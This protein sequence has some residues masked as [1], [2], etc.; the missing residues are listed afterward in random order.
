MAP[1]S[2]ATCAG[3]PRHSV[4]YSLGFEGKTEH[5]PNAHVLTLATM[6]GHGMV[7]MSLAKK[8]IDWV[9][10]G[11]RTPEQACHYLTRFCSCGVFNPVA[12]EAD[13]RG[14]PRELAVTLRR[15][16]TSLAVALLAATGCSAPPQPSA[17]AAT[18]AAPAGSTLVLRGFTLID[19]NGGAPIA[20]AGLV[21][22]NGRITYVGPGAN[23][24]AP[25]GASVQDLTG[26]FVMPGLI[27]LHG[28]VAESDGI[29]QDPKTLFTRENVLANLKLYATYGVTT[30]ASMGTDQPIVYDL[31]R[32]QRAGR[33]SEAR[34]FTAGRGFTSTKGYPTQPGGIPGVPYELGK[35][36]DAAAPMAEL[37]AH[38][39]DMVKM[40]VDDHLGVLPKMPIPVAKALIDAA[41]GH[42][43]KAVAHVFYADDALKLSE[44]GLDAFMHSVRDRTLTA[45]EV[46]RSSSVARGWWRR[47]SRERR[48][49]SNWRRLTP[50]SRTRSSC[51][52][53]PRRSWR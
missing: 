8:M 50:C 10:E 42:K 29:T 52:P 9:K 11:R 51:A 25:A 41:H 6:C 46:A 27:N 16:L 4:G 36:E 14:R 31:I 26:A 33:P 18:S 20:N 48:R 1:S 12:R 5:L 19:G 30:V 35:P 47:R 24:N 21:A 38:R 53:S 39:P 37:A 34:I 28:H 13:S 15:L 7:S 40:W 44:A 32:E 17:P 45:A 22:E 2:A 43:L 23:M 49:C 3:I